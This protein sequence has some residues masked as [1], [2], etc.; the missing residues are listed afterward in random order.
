M[1]KDLIRQIIAA[2]NAPEPPA[3]LVNPEDGVE[4]K[5]GFAMDT[6]ENTNDPNDAAG[7]ECG[8]TLC[9]AGWAVAL[10][11]RKR[12]VRHAMA[13]RGDNPFNRELITDWEGEGRELLG[14]SASEANR[15]FLPVDDEG[16][17]YNFEEITVAQ[18]TAVLEHL[19]AE[20][21]VD[22]QRV[23]GPAFEKLDDR[24]DEEED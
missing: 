23:L 18:A 1:N 20:G 22:W 5:L 2:I 4:V 6:F 8:T 10:G 17:T 24:E 19:L 11:D 13:E 15:L 12:Y 14:L 16:D 9:I 3:L 7:R 21:D